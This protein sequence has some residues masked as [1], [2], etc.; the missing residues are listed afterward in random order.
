MT[1]VQTTSATY[2]TK[3]LIVD[4]HPLVRHGIRELISDEPDLEP[5]GEADDVE[6][7]LRHLEHADPDLAVVDI[8]LKA[9]NGLDLVWR[10][11]AEAPSVKTLVVSVYDDTLY[12]KR[13]L[14]AGA[15]GFVNKRQLKDVLIDAIRHVIQGALFLRPDIAYELLQQCASEP[16]PSGAVEQLSDFELRVFELIGQGFTTRQI[17]HRLDLNLETI[18][19]HRANI[20]ERLGLKTTC[21]LARHAARWVLDNE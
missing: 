6:S 2:S 21:E 19:T 3:V 17:A 11:H 7:A 13:A 8:S 14:R 15:D 12:A 5:C 20:T 10:M 4:D 18:K 9:S 1:T 16:A